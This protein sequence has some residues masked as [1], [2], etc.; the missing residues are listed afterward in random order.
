MCKKK[1][2]VSKKKFN[3]HMYILILSQICKEYDYA[4]LR[5]Y[6]KKNYILKFGF[7]VHDDWRMCTF[8]WQIC[9][10]ME[11]FVFSLCMPHEQL[12]DYNWQL[13][14]DNMFNKILY[15]KFHNNI[16]SSWARVNIKYISTFT[17]IKKSIGILKLNVK[18]IFISY[19]KHV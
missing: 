10:Y 15:L 4:F 7:R 5:K 9:R 3:L 12:I 6:A 2:G 17:S 14:I 1:C 16:V 13:T 19:I 8:A 11:C 18:I